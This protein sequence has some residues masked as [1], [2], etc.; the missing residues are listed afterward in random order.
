MT[1]YSVTARIT[2]TEVRNCPIGVTGPVYHRFSLRREGDS[3]PFLVSD[4]LLENHYTF[5]NIPIGMYY[6]RSEMKLY[7]PGYTNDTEIAG[8][9]FVLTIPNEIMYDHPLGMAVTYV[10]E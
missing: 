1:T 7:G 3:T 9:D 6:V 4:D 8:Y 10:A 5:Q 2:A